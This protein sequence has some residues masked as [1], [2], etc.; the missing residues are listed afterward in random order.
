MFLSAFFG[1]N[2][3]TKTYSL[4]FASKYF[5]LHFSVRNPA[6]Q[7]FSSFLDQRSR[8]SFLKKD[9]FIDIGHIADDDEPQI[10]HILVRHR[11]D[12]DRFYLLYAVEKLERPTPSAADQFVLGQV[13]CLR[14]VRFLAAVF[15]LGE[16]GW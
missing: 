14:G 3:A 12:L 16:K 9:R 10:F 11:L 15:G 7:T 6:F 13:F 2:L 1:S 8:P 5:L 4:R